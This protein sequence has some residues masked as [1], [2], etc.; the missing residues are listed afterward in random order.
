MSV[1]TEQVAPPEPTA[2][3]PSRVLVL[4]DAEQR[5]IIDMFVNA[6]TVG[7]DAHRLVQRVAYGDEYANPADELARITL[8]KRR[9][10]EEVRRCNKAIA[11]VEEQVCEDLAS[12]G[13]TSVKHAATGATLLL[14]QKIWAKLDVETEGLPKE[15]AD[16]I[17]AAIKARA[18]RALIDAGLGHLV[19]EDFNLNTVSAV[20]REQIKAYNAE[21]AD[22]P[23]H[24]RVPRAP[25][26]FLPDELRGL[27][28]I[29]N[30]PHISVRA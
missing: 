8:R 22:L 26:S 25:E 30:T 14:D 4:N 19:R 23:E 6:S 11:S 7:L 9:L 10:E 29:D 16:E 27:L 15:E 21:Q 13:L 28:R 12:E 20:F 3:E 24:E 5:A 2:I 18:G 1:E 17:R